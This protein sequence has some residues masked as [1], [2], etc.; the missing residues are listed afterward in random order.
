MPGLV[1]DDPGAYAIPMNISAVSMDLSGSYLR[2]VVGMSVLSKSL[3]G[4]EERAAEL[5]KSLGTPAP[6]PEGAG[7]LVDLYA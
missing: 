1:D 5:F 7:T 2:D 4:E 6:L 3:K